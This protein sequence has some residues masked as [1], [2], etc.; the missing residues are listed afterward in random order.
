MAWRSKQEPAGPSY[1]GVRAAYGREEWDVVVRHGPV[2]LAEVE[3]HLAWED[4]PGRVQLLRQSAD[5]RARIGVAHTRLDEPGPGA[6]WLR[7][8][9]DAGYADRTPIHTDY[10]L[11]VL[12]LDESKTGRYSRV[13]PVLDELQR[14]GSPSRRAA[15]HRLRAAILWRTTADF[16]R[17][18]S[19]LEQSVLADPPTEPGLWWHD[20]VYRA[21]FFLDAGRYDEARRFAEPAVAQQ[22]RLADPGKPGTMTD[23]GVSFGILSRCLAATGDLER[24]REYL[25]AGRRLVAHRRYAMAYSLKSEADWYIAAG[26]PDAAERAIGEAWVLANELDLMP[27]LVELL[28][29][30]LRVCQL[31]VDDREFA[32]RRAQALDLCRLLGHVAHRQ[33]IESLGS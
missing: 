33:V 24:A 6:D 1:D 19:E 32:R 16:A 3:G 23:L 14:I 25:E 4:G 21:G 18:G 29:C 20:G 12:A 27:T 5:L 7:S 8:I 13:H 11:F 26:D 9:V 31:R 2:V 28:I 17:A 30:Q 22:Q 10:L 15:A